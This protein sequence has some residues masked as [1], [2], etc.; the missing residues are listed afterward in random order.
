MSA[1]VK[2]ANMAVFPLKLEG[3]KWN[4]GMTYK[5]ALVLALASNPEMIAIR[6]R[7]GFTYIDG[8]ITG[9]RIILQADTIIAALEAE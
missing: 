3:G 6:E 1:K 9:D 8:K 4:A 5:Q 2:L 7:D